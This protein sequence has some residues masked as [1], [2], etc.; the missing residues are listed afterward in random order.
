MSSVKKLVSVSV[1][2]S[3][4]ACASVNPA[5]LAKLVALD[6]L[7]AD[8]AAISVAARLPESLKLRDG[9]LV[10]KI[11]IDGTESGIRLKEEFKLDIDD[12]PSNGAGTIVPGP[13]EVLQTARVTQADIER[14]KQ[15]QAKGREHKAKSTKKDEGSLSILITGGCKSADIPTGALPVSIYLK[16]DAEVGYYPVFSGLDLRRQLGE[17]VIGAIVACE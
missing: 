5:A 3:L 8:P 17:K 2:L 15:V 14:L 11:E 16:T 13:G 12:A 7:T 9:D 1:F 4:S 6:P 10:M